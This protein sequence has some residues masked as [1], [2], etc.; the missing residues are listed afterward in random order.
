MS[1][2][3]MIIIDFFAGPRLAETKKPQ[4]TAC[5]GV[6][7]CC[8][9]VQ[10]QA[11]VRRAGKVIPTGKG[12]GKLLTAINH[13]GIVVKWEAQSKLYDWEEVGVGNSGLR[14]RSVVK[15]TSNPKHQ[16]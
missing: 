5:G 10:S 14:S 8:C 4:A 11:P 7:G 2:F 16:T 9:S 1:A 3:R 6:S 13:G 12:T 15:E